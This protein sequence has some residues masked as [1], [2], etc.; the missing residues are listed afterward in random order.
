MDSMCLLGLSAL[1]LQITVHRSVYKRERFDSLQFQ[2][3]WYGVYAEVAV[4]RQ[5]VDET[6]AMGGQPAPE[7]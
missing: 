7:A 6:M 2:A 4:L 5:W 3:G 1:D